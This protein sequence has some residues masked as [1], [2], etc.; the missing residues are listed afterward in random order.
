[1]AIGLGGNVGDTRAAFAFAL[2]RLREPLTPLRVSPLYRT[3]PLGGPPQPDYLNAVAVGETSL[4]PRALLDL[5]LLVEREAGRV[6]SKEVASGP[7]VLDLD[8][9][10]YGDDVVEEPGLSVPHPRIAE[11]RFV[12]QPL[13]ALAPGW[14][15]PGLG[16]DVTALL[17]AAP[18]ARVRAAGSLGRRWR[19][20]PGP[21]LRPGSAPRATA[22][23]RRDAT[24]PG[25][26]PGS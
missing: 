2:G 22:R 12:L 19:G 6:R 20:R 9:L 21:D 8:L 5:L 13:S 16:R 1:M 18:R 23:S 17:A 4:P 11:R 14:V 3:A 7:R 26:G 25:Q 15:V 24:R 10:L